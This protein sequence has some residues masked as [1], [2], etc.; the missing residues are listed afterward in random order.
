MKIKLLT[1]PIVLLGIA[2]I[3]GCRSN[4]QTTAMNH[5]TKGT[6]ASQTVA[7]LSSDVM[8]SLS[9]EWSVTSIGDS[10]LD[11]DKLPIVTLEQPENPTAENVNTL[12]C[13][14]NG[15]CNTI[16][17]Q[18]TVAAGN[19]IKPSGDFISTMMLCPDP[20][21]DLLMGQAFA[22]V[23]KYSLAETDSEATL[24]LYDA[25]GAKVMGLRKHDIDFLNG[26]W[27]VTAI[28]GNP[29]DPETGMEMVI[30]L[31]EHRVHINGGCN[32]INGSIDTVM[33]VA[34]GIKLSNMSSTRMT[35]PYIELEY[36][37]LQNLENVTKC[38][39]AGKKDTALLEDASGKVL[40]TLT[41]M[42]LDVK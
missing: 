12:L 14:A 37:L 30:D 13:Y 29:I 16:N 10:L 2:A 42:E 19:A 4:Q 39:R 41:R 11:V 20:N 6:A 3:T 8:D 21:F 33:G 27:R 7:K 5:P 23:A 32:I 25:K 26:A 24:S 18:F 36:A 40:V 22:K 31:P 38:V 1:L 28:E 9:G 15:G 34:A 17:G 35:C